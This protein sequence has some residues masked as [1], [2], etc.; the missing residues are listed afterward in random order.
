V[1]KSVPSTVSGQT[2]I[3]LKDKRHDWLDHST[4]RIEAAFVIWR[5][6]DAFPG[7]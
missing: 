5:Q 2:P 6:M 4:S 1:F 7:N 3:V